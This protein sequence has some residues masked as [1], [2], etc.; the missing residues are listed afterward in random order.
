MSPPK[1]WG[2]TTWCIDPK[3]RIH[4]KASEMCTIVNNITHFTLIKLHRTEQMDENGVPSVGAT[5]TRM[6][7]CRGRPCREFPFGGARTTGKRSGVI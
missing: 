5:S 3:D 2:V 1:L 7:I 4:V 6:G